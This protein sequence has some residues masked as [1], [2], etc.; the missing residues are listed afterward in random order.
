[1]RESEASIP[2]RQSLLSRLKNFEDQES[3]QDFFNTY[4][5][6]IYGLAV[7]SGLSDAEAQDVVQETVI[8][9]VKHIPK[10]KYDPNRGS[11]KHWLLKMTR[12]RI[13]DQ[14]RGRQ[15]AE[16]LPDRFE[17]ELDGGIEAPQRNEFEKLWDQEWKDNLLTVALERVKVRIDPRQYQIFE[18]CEVQK[19]PV[20]RVASTL[21]I[22]AARIYLTKHRVSA[23]LKKEIKALNQADW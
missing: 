6:T 10:F 7:Q 15:K 16:P 12:W 4:W 1:M 18:L 14:R 11:F 21:G 13:I 22:T 19:W 3:W 9:V 20:A 5:R 17:D 2:T 23:E 8:S